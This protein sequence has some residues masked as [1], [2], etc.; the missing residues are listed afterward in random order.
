MD[1]SDRNQISK[2]IAYKLKDTKESLK[3]QY[4]ETK[5]GIGYF[6][7]D[8]L[9][10]D[11]IVHEVFTHFPSSKEITLKKSLKEF[12]YVDAQMDR[13]NHLLED[14]IY[15][16][17]D[18]KVIEQ[19]EDICD[20]SNIQPDSHLY[21]GGI[22]IMEKGNFLNPHLDN[23]HD[24]E[25]EL[26][27]VMNLLYYVTPDWKLSNGGNLELWPE[28]IKGEPIT[29]ESK[30]N[31]LVVMITHKKSWH[32]VSE[33]MVDRARCCVSNYYFSD[34]SIDNEASFH[35]TTF[36]ARPGEFFKNH[37]LKLDAT[38]RMGIRKIFK[39]GIRENPHVYKKTDDFSED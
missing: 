21:A 38:I 4:L 24:K 10:P 8:D 14:L 36:R 19:I 16:F 39:K 34:V 27:R 29:I 28:G 13:Y 18:Q 30:F 25:R 32:S 17:Q 15:A 2:L 3:Q 31:R 37:V 20:M 9:L 35:V 26:W 33:V 1:Y 11:A 6:F 7:L 22:S 12:K 23:S 5:E